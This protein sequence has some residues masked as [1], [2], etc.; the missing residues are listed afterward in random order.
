MSATKAGAN[1]P[2]PILAATRAP[3]DRNRRGCRG[4]TAIRIGARVAGGRDSPSPRPT[5]RAHA[6]TRAPSRELDRDVVESVARA[7]RARE[8]DSARCGR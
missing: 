3:R 8:E 7:Q 1:S 4:S 2:R 6:P 5:T